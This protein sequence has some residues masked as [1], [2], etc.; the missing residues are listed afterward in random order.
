MEIIPSGQSLGACIERTVPNAVAD[1]TPAAPR[2][3]RRVQMPATLDHPAPA[4]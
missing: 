2:T 1:G 3:M 4:A